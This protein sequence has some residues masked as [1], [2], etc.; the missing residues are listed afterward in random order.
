MNFGKF[1]DQKVFYNGGEWE[2]YY[3]QA[4]HLSQ[5]YYC[6]VMLR[7][8]EWRLNFYSTLT[9]GPDIHTFQTSYM[10]TGLRLQQAK[11]AKIRA[12]PQCTGK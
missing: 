12:I 10:T 1:E 4:V 7:E 11:S 3:Q 2:I 8:S 5:Q 9:E 6:T